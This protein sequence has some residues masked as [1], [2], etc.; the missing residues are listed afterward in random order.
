MWHAPGPCAPIAATRAGRKAG[1]KF[2]AQTKT[3]Q[4]QRGEDEI[5][6]GVGHSTRVPSPASWAPL[7]VPQLSLG[8]KGRAHATVLFGA[9]PELYFAVAFV[10]FIIII[11]LTLPPLIIVI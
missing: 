4:R 10:S 11:N 8:H 3:P 1:P 9:E 5:H 2:W 6:E 7:P